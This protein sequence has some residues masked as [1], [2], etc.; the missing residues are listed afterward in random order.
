MKFLH[1]SDLHLGKRVNEFSMIEDQ[2][3][4]LKEI[5]SIV[6]K[7]QPEGILI[8]GD[9]YDRSIPTEDAMRLWDEFLISLAGKKV[10]VYAISGNHDS[11]IRFSNHSA[12]VEEAGIYLAPAYDG[13]CQ[14]YQLADENGTVNI[15]LLPFIKPTMV[16]SAFPEEEM[17]DYNDACRVAIEHMDMNREERNIL[18]A[19]QFVLGATRCDSEEVSVGGLDGVSAD[20]FEGI[21]YVAL[22]HIHGKQ[23]VGKETIRYCGTPL[24]YSFSEKDHKKSVTVVELREKGV[25]EIR[26]IPLTPLHDLRE[27]R[28]SY[29]E[30]M[31]KKNYEGTATDDYIHAVLTDEND[32][33]DAVAKLRVVYPNLMKLSYDNK[34]T[35]TQQTVT[36]A[37]QVEKKT[38]IELFSEFFEKQNNQE[39]T[40]EQKS[41]VLD[42]MEEIWEV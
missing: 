22:G 7:E 14:K 37:K 27:I 13:T 40:E 2:R 12:L 34:R 18:V 24:K 21:D 11:A 23:K 20:V 29:E 26:E 4:I 42:Q 15:Y 8:A 6:N 16:R 5:L 25:V 38:P 17:K 28:G 10:P 19:H 33:I 32:V 41:F 3:Y 31:A 36:E 30:L 35:R 1:L 9:V 39:L